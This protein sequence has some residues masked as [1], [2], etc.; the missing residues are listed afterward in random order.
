MDNGKI[1]DFSKMEKKWQKKWVESGIFKAGENSKKDKYYVLEMFPYPSASYLHMGHVRCYSI[2]DII[3]RYK[4]MKGFSV[5][6][7]IGFDAFGLP[8]ENA[9]IKDKIHPKKYTENAIKNIERLM[10]AIGLSYDW[11]RSLS[12]CDSSYYKWNQWIFLKMF[13]KGIAYRKKAPVNWCPSCKTVLAN[14]EVIN[15]KCWRCDSEVIL[16]QLE[17][18]F[19]KIT[20]YADELLAGLDKIDWPEKVKS[21][22]RNWIGRSEGTKV[23]FE[24][25]NFGK[26]IKDLEFVFLHAYGDKINNSFWL[27][28]KK[29]I[30]SRG[31]K[32]YFFKNLPNTDSPD[33]KEQSEFVL[34]NYKFNENS[35]VVAHSLGNILMMKILEKIDCKIN[36]MIMVAPPFP[37]SSKEIIN[38]MAFLD[39]KPRQALAKYCDW[40]FDIKEISKKVEEVIILADEKDRIVPISQPIE[41]AEKLN[42]KIIRTIAKKS[43]F[44]G[45][46]E[47][48]IL[49][50]IFNL[51]GS[52]K[53]IEVFT[54]RPDTLMGVT[55][56]VYSAQHPFVK[57]LVQGTSYEKE[58]NNFVKKISASQKLDAEK[59]KEGFFTGRY[60][61]HPLTG[62]EVPI[63]ASN[64][65]LADY[66][67]G[68]VMAVPAHDQRDF[69]FA[70]KYK[71]DIKIVIEPIGEKSIDLKSMKEAYVSGGMLVNSGEFNGLVHEEAKEHITKALEYKGKGGKVVEYRLRDWL[72][73]RQRYWGTPIP[74]IYC[75]DCGAVP[76]SEKD[77]PVIL[78][79]KVEFTGKGNPLAGNSKFLN[80]K[81]PKCGG[82]G[83]RE[84]DTMATFFDSSWYFLRYC[85][86]NNKKKIFDEKKEDYWMPADQYVG[87]VEHA[88]LHLLYSRF[89]TKFLR[90]IKLL[91]FDEP[92][93]RLFNQG[94]V[95]KDGQRMSKS[96]NNTVTAEEIA[97]RYGI[98]SAR[99]FLSF[100][101]SPE[102][103]I[104][105]DSHGIEGAYRMVNRFISLS[106]KIGGK[107]DEIMEHKINKILK[108]M[109]ECYSK[110]EFNKSIILFMELVNYLSDKSQVP[111]NLFEKMILA[112]SPVIPHVAEEMWEKIGNKKM[113][114]EQKWPEFDEKKIDEKF[115]KA[116]EASLRV[117]SDILNIL[118]IIK[119]RTGKEG[120]KVYLYIIPN[121]EGF[122]SADLI[123]NRTGRKVFIYKVNDK[124]KYDPESKAQKAKP[125]K[126]AIYIE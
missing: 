109:D 60:A 4:R 112:I 108:I 42:A 93:L 17:Q 61:V 118:K 79:E 50:T 10:K 76:V 39:N 101:A 107:S 18:W 37:K 45:Q 36:K 96:K 86:S 73:S 47:P 12:T 82:K 120:E 51:K 59:S 41:L 72:I 67:T 21:M 116:E 28:L 124:N 55:F 99:L 84:S 87:G 126:P 15:G 114:I 35:V 20:D 105:W 125:Q 46:E 68:V 25:D 26:S 88:V 48:D 92:F 64:F 91:K 75:D 58:Y 32:V 122:Y 1:I 3:A 98:D 71:I 5:L 44:N 43:H 117:V 77:L 49:D 29:E 16:E 94:I 104:E 70:K 40:K 13:E 8:A 30:E 90:D 63:Y 38:G 119:E 31:G 80:V 24:I 66:G 11:D 52:K 85:D 95:H 100:V 113:V 103:D 33:F 53:N 22:Q 34:Q 27:W 81:C 78:P 111:K 89:F 115:D 106:D 74:I 97:D 69:E 54:T 65:V 123:E 14:E 7:P 23:I 9:A 110:F 83:R 102:K 2:G 57:E 121:E 62:E 19:L 56:L 6:Y